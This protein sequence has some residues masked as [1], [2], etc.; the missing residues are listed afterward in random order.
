LVAEVRETLPVSKQA[1]QKVEMERFNLN[2]LN[3][4]EVKEQYQVKIS[5]SF[6][7]LEIFSNVKL[8]ELSGARKGNICKNYKLK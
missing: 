4:P 6:V 8:V 1:V 3:D 5:K 2:R 7:A